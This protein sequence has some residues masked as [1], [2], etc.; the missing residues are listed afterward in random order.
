M[1]SALRS[2]SVRRSFSRCNF[3]F[4]SPNGAARGFRTTLSWLKPLL[5]AG[6]PIT[7]PLH[8]VRRVQTFAPQEGTDGA[9]SGCLVGLRQNLLLVLG[10]E[11]PALRFGHHFRVWAD[12]GCRIGFGCAHRCTPFGLAS[13]GLTT[14]RAGHSR[15]SQRLNFVLHLVSSFR[16]AQ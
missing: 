3:A 5:N 6:L 12:S 2:C 7:P 13:L 11:P 16:P 15:R 8:Q 9:T 10:G 1:S 4:S 14:F